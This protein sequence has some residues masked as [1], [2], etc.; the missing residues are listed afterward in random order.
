MLIPL[1]FKLLLG[2]QIHDAIDVFAASRHLVLPAL[3]FSSFLH[4]RIFDSTSSLQPQLEKL[5]TKL[6]T[7]CRTLFHQ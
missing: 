5:S 1:V 7:C 6:K 2:W 4:F 3:N